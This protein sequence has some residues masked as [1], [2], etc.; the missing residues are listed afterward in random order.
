MQVFTPVFGFS[1]VL[2]YKS[3]YYSLFWYDNCCHSVEIVLTVMT[4]TRQRMTENEILYFI[5]YVH[6][7]RLCYI[8]IN[9]VRHRV[10]DSGLPP[11]PPPNFRIQNTPKTFGACRICRYV[12]AVTGGFKV[13]NIAQ[14][15]TRRANKVVYFCSHIVTL[16]FCKPW[17]SSEI[18]N[19]GS[20]AAPFLET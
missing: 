9:K 7:Y 18:W 3:T 4:S 1:Y 15:A 5:Q 6:Y 2:C 17:R 11:P 14:H 12:A 10:I 16:L 20:F 13:T 19:F 8:C